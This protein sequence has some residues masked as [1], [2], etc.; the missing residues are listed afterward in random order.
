MAPILSAMQYFAEK[1]ADVQTK[2]LF[3]LEAAGL[4]NGVKP[5]REVE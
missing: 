2:V 5:R 4:P 3:Y 1:T